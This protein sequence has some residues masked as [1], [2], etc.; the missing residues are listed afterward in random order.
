M[1][2]LGT[3]RIL[4]LAPVGRDA[5]AT[6]DLLDKANLQPHVCGSLDAL[7]DAL[8][9]GAAA[10]FVAEEALFGRDLGRL[11]AWIAAQ[12]VWSDLPFVVL[13]SRRHDLRVAAWR[14]ALVRSLGNVSLVERPVHPIT[15]SST[16]QAAV[17]ARHRQYEV[18]AL[19]EGEEAAGE[20]AREA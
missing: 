9:Q 15:L 19:L 2:A 14:Q 3:E 12:P 10:A 17:R 4:V 20:V 8:V 16:L 7:V 1:T 11:L 13:T 6:A 5:P 18:R